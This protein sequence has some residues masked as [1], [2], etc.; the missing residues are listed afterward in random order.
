MKRDKRTPDPELPPHSYEAEEAALGCVLWAAK[1]DPSQQAELDALLGQLSPRLFFDLRNTDVWSSMVEM[2]NEQHAVTLITLVQWMKDRHKHTFEE[3]S[4]RLSS[5]ME[6]VPGWSGF[7]TYLDVLKD[8]ALRRDIL[9]RRSQLTELAESEDLSP[10]RLREAMADLY[11]RTA[12]ATTSR[13]LIEIVSLKEIK[14]YVPDP[15]TFLVGDDMI[16]RGEISVIA[17]LPEAG[18]SML[19]NTLAFAGA[20][21]KRDWMGYRIRRKFRTLVLQSEGSMRRMQKEFAEAGDSAQEWVKFSKPA[22]LAFG[23]PAFRRQLHQYYERW[24]WDLTIIDNWSDCVRDDKFADYQEGLDNIRAALP[25]GD[26]TP[27]TLIVAH[28]SKAVIKSDK[29]MTGRALMAHVSGSFRI[30]Q[31]ARCVFTLV[32]AFPQENDDDLVIFDCAKASNDTPNPLSAWHR[33][34]VKFIADPKFDT[35]AWLNPAVDGDRVDALVALQEVLPAE[36]SLARSRIASEISDKYGVGE[37]TVFRWITNALKAGKVT[38]ENKLVRWN[39][40]D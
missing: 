20:D 9:R 21:G 39:Y 35:H 30:G 11:E 29:P 37:S 3:I 18:K 33:R 16:N 34:P 2:R 28:L 19:A 26:A 15:K 22:H 31:K 24:P 38:E 13:P 36:A 7:V 14:A 1:D 10:E 25:A 12:A 27:A 4:F 32:R 5:M 8:K 17:G 6:L 23:D 40:E